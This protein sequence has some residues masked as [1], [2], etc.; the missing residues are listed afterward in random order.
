MLITARHST[1]LLA[2][3]LLSFFPPVFSA[4]TAT[5]KTLT[6]PSGEEFSFDVYRNTKQKPN[7]RILWIAPDFGIDPRIRETAEAL[8]KLNTEVWLIDL[9]DALFLTRGAQTMREIP[10]ELVADL[11]NALAQQTANTSELLIVS[12]RYGA[13]PALRGVHAWQAQPT[14]QGKLIGSVF[15][16]PSFFTH[17]PELGTAPSFINELAATNSPIYIFQSANNSV[18]WHLPAVLTA[19]QHATVYTELLKGTM[20]VFYHKDDSPNSVAAFERAPK[21]ILRAAKQLRQHTMSSAPLPITIT[22]SAE[23]SGIN[24]RLKQYRG[25]VTP[26]PI[27]LRDATGKQF[28]IQTFSGKVTLVNFWAT[29]CGPCI[30]EIPSLNRLKQTMQG[31]PFQLI[32]VN[33]AESAKDIIAFLKMVDVDFPVL[34]DPGGELTGKWKVVAFPST[35]VIGPDGKIHYG[36]NAGIHWDT[37]DVIQ[38][39]NKLLPTPKN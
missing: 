14:P 24:T 8:T 32:S 17:V 1:A 20:S 30:E 26:T 37:K 31:K 13:I 12:S 4:D 16:S 36:V 23:H 34:I 6:T 29:W 25:S 19:L 5:Q 28:N 22:G 39:L 11:I 33:Y 38:Q 18:R 15:F 3:L 35:F 2:C 9:V 10:G 21:M 27:K 7:L